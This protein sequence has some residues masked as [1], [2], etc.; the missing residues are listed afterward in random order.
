MRVLLH[1]MTASKIAHVVDDDDDVD[2]VSIGVD[3]ED[4]I[5]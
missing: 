4:V 1:R 3:A 2:D 5:A